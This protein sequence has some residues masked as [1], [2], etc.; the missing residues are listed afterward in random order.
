ML[1]VFAVAGLGSFA[2]L[3]WLTSRWLGVTRMPA[4]SNALEPVASPPAIAVDSAPS[5][6]VWVP[7]AAPQTPVLVRVRRKPYPATGHA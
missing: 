4:T 3:A 2:A 5:A 6:P 7:L 1:C